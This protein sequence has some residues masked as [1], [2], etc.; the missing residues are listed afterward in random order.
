MTIHTNVISFLQHLFLCGFT[1]ERIDP[2][3]PPTGGK[4]PPMEGYPYV[5][6]GGGGRYRR[7]L[8]FPPYFILWTNLPVLYVFKEYEAVSHM[9]KGFFCV[10]SVDCTGPS[11]FILKGRYG[12]WMHVCNNRQ[13]WEE[14]VVFMMWFRIFLFITVFSHY[15]VFM[16]LCCFIVLPIYD[17]YIF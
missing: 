13:V 2:L 4:S 1:L 16:T 8:L 7:I 9:G 10:P 14:V 12:T 15:H 3:S 11:A 6:S 5:R 17:I